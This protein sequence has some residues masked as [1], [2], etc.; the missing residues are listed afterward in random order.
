MTQTN[1]SDVPL[2]ARDIEREL[3]S[4]RRTAYFDWE[5]AN[6]TLQKRLLARRPILDPIPADDD[7]RFLEAI[8]ETR[9]AARHWEYTTKRYR[10]WRRRRKR[11]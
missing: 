5:H 10:R 8:E 9:L 4:D 3:L 6:E 11:R 1:D 2:P 7:E